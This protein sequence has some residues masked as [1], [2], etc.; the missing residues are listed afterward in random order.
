MPKAFVRDPFVELNKLESRSR[1]S[2]LVYPEEP[3]QAA[4]RTA[5]SGMTVVAVS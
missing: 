2:A 5:L 4:S 3:P 1:T